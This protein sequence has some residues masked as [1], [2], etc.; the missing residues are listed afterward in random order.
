MDVFI[1]F[2]LEIRIKRIQIKWKVN[3]WPAGNKCK[4]NINKLIEIHCE[5]I[6]ST[7]T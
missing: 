1:W 6:F 3:V 5:C 2:R 7:L 4:V